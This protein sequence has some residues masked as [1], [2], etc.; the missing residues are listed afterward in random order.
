MDAQEPPPYVYAATDLR[1]R[2]PREV[3]LCTRASSFDWQYTGA[4]AVA[5]GTSIWF[6]VKEFKESNSAA[7][8]LA[9]PA[10]VGFSTGGLLSGAYLSLPKCDP[11][12]AEGPPPE[13]NVRS[14]IPLAIVISVVST[15]MGPVF[16]YSY[17]GPVKTQWPVFERSAR[18]FV[19]GGTALL[20]S[21]FPY[22][23]P[24]KTWAAKRQIER[25]RVEGTAGGAA[26]S[27]TLQF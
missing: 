24:P 7:V 9:G 25:M 10:L 3:E 12:W 18:I 20:G 11:M 26:V 15:V 19:A 22:L 4:F 8:R 6:N 5:F 17:L 27:Y 13:G 1:P 2:Q 16:D 21:L 14:H 23:L